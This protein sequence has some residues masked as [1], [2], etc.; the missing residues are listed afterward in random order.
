MRKK[1]VT[2]I[3]VILFG[4]LSVF[5]QKH[6]I[7]T[8]SVNDGLPSSYI[9]D[10]IID[11]LG[12][13]W[14]ATA[15]GLVKYDGKQFQTYTSE[16]GLIDELISDIY[17]DR[18]GNLWVATELGGVAKFVHDSLIYIP[19]LSE[20]DSLLVHFISAGPNGKLW[21]GT[22]EKGI[23]EWEYGKSLTPK[24]SIE[25]GLPSNQIWDFSMDR[26]GNFWI[27]TSNGIALYKEDGGVT[28]TLTEQNGLSGKLAYQ[29]FEDTEGNKWIPTSNG[30]T[31][32]KPDLSIEI[33]SKINGL[34]LGYVYS[35]AQDDRGDIWIGTERIGLFI[36][37]GTNFTQIKKRNGLSSN[38]VY[39]LV[40]DSDGNIWI[41]TDGDGISIL[42]NRDFLI[43][44]SSS[45]LKANTV[46]S[47]LKHSD[48]SI[49]IGT[50]NGIS[51]LK[52]E[53]FTNYTIP[54]KYF[55]EGEI[56]DIE[57]LPNGNILLL[58]IDYDIFEFDG[59]S[60]FHPTFFDDIYDYFVSDIFVDKEDGSIWF[61]AFQMLLKYKDGELTKYPPP[62]E[63]YWQ[64]NLNSIFKDSR[65]T[66]WIGTNAGVANFKDGDF[67]YITAKDGLEGGSIYDIK[68]D[69]YGNLWI[70]TNKG[71][72]NLSDFDSTGM[73]RKI[74]PF[75]TLDLY[76]QETIF[77]QFDELGNL[78][79]ATNGGM[80]YYE[81]EDW[82]EGEMAN[83][84]HF[85]FN[86]FGHGI[87]FNGV[88]SI[89]DNDGSLWFGTNSKGLIKVKNTINKNKKKEVVPKVFLREITANNEL[90]Y[91]Q[92][93]EE[94]DSS[95]KVPFDQNNINFKFNGIDFKNPN[96]IAYKYKLEGFDK[97]WQ[98]ANDISEVRYTSIPYGSYNLLVS[99]KSIKSNWGE[100]TSL[101]TITI[102]KP[103]WLQLW[104]FFLIG[105]SLIMVV[106]TYIRMTVARSEKKSLKLLVD[107]QTKDIQASLEEKEVLIKEIHHRVKNNLAVV[108]GLLEL[109]SWNL[110]DGEAKNAMLESRLR[111]LAMSKIH[112]NLYQNK[113]LAKVD[114]KHF[115]EELISGI[116]ISMKTS[117]KEIDVTLDLDKALLDINTGIPIGLIT[118]EIISN[119]FKHAFHEKENGKIDVQFKDRESSYLL[120]ISD[121]GIGSEEDL[122]NK[123]SS[124]SLGMTLVKSLASQINAKITFLN[125]AGSIFE[126]IIPKKVIS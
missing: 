99:A 89:L 13:G 29:V 85:P 102:E 62:N 82:T 1:A 50:E 49:W 125:N 61:A 43:Y 95:I 84:K 25:N 81:L 44:D 119:C 66:L 54:K 36:Y 80:N 87:E 21:F 71:I 59:K 72:Y 77:L 94:S 107:E 26:E 51:N 67:K 58:G 39:R 55:D 112:E 120:V 46:F 23:Y 11:D 100:A 27:S 69:S 83:Q 37:D 33:I 103:Y 97:D 111:I 7:K 96:R 5:A 108:S 113:D 47:T 116:S 124:S 60:F 3:G 56:W 45:Q 65:G 122:L 48:G 98:Y 15:N 52:N 57:E 10:I 38:F 4:V 42:R 117:G 126:I 20:L 101:S 121:N 110:P 32:I 31:I 12:I 22:D 53:K 90:I 17:K 105:T 28:Y 19:E 14:F 93:N 8:Y 86:D 91:D 115:L 63:V 16:D 76:M 123:E 104:F 106:F 88:A 35:I 40:N 2:F 79:Q 78:W 64:T 41:A 75:E 18:L 34:D 114:F 24:L 92:L 6:D 74:I 118:N 9:Y 70:G 30:I 68:E 109:Q 73:P